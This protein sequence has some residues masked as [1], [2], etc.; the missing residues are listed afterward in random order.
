MI[1]ALFLDDWNNQ[2]MF[3]RNSTLLSIIELN[4]LYCSI[5][6]HVPGKPLTKRWWTILL[7]WYSYQ[8][9]FQRS[10]SMFD[11]VIS[12]RQ[13][14][15]KEISRTTTFLQMLVELNILVIEFMETIP[16]PPFYCSHCQ[17]NHIYWRIWVKVSLLWKPRI[18]ITMKRDW[19]MN[20][21]RKR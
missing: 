20:K 9:L 7:R 14:I 5:W 12:L 2:C 8:I 6:N 1:D 19:E 4:Q 16:F 10:R 18:R 11:I 17:W 13:R 21:M 15:K 3:Q